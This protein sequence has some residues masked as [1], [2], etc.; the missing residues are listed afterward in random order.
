M[1]HL[2]RLVGAEEDDVRDRWH[3]EERQREAEVRQGQVQVPC[4]SRYQALTLSISAEPA[5]HDATKTCR[6]R[7]TNDGVNTT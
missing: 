4:L 6:I 1:R 2:D 7:G 5:V 3:D